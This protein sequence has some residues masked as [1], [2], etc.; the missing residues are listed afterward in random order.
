MVEVCRQC[1]MAVVGPTTRLPHALP[2]L[3]LYEDTQSPQVRQGCFHANQVDNGCMALSI[4]GRNGKQCR[5][6]YM[7]H[8]KPRLKI[9]ECLS[10]DS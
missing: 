8:L 9:E 5:E 3:M 6:R 4:P 7:N 2:R 1:A 10:V